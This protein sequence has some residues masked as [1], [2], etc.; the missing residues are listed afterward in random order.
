[1]IYIKRGYELFEEKK[2]G[3]EYGDGS[4][5]QHFCELSH[6]LKFGSNMLLS[7]YARV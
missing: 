5:L 3:D 1:M 6:L 7:K 2:E 4:L